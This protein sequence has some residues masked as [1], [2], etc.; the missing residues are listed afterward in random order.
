MTQMFDQAIVMILIEGDVRHR[1]RRRWTVEGGIDPDRLRRGESCGIDQSRRFDITVQHSD[2]PFD[3]AENASNSRI[4][5]RDERG[6]PI[7]V[8]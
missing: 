6:K 8:L 2:Q 7:G 5:I 4:V 1:G 3:I